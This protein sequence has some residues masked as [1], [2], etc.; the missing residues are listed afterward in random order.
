MEKL[1]LL[2]LS[3]RYERYQVQKRI[4]I[5]YSINLFAGG[6]GNI[7]AYAINEMDGVAGYRGWRWIFVGFPPS[8]STI[9]L[10]V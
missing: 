4:A 8:I 5:F 9:S 6:F 1:R 7:L 2:T 10:S 3:Y